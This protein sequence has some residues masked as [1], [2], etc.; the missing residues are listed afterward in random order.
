MLTGFL[1]GILTANPVANF[2][3][4]LKI[5]QMVFLMAFLMVS[6]MNV[7]LVVFTASLNSIMILYIISNDRS[8]Y[9]AAVPATVS[10]RFSNP[11]WRNRAVLRSVQPFNELS[12]VP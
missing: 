7:V 10:W 4:A 3:A 2:M 5:F 11:I 1:L 12:M 8:S 9:W 6:L